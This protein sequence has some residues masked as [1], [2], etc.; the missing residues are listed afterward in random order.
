MSGIKRKEKKMSSLH[1]KTPNKM[2]VTKKRR[3]FTVML[4][5]NNNEMMKKK[6]NNK[7]KIVIEYCLFFVPIKYIQKNKT[8]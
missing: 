5:N 7:N 2:N 8:H 6:K 3:K 4:N 1:F